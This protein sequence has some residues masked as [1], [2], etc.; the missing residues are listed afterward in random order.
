MSNE[1]MREAHMSKAL[2]IH[3]ERSSTD[4]PVGPAKMTE[5]GA[6]ASTVKVEDL[7][8]ERKERLRAAIR[9]HA[10]NERKKRNAKAGRPLA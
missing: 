6:T 8:D 2:E 5:D 4:R 9:T 7:N 1:S 10:L 3:D